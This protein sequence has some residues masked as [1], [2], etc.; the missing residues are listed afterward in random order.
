[1]SEIEKMYE[2]AGCT[3]MW[4]QRYNDGYYEHEHHYNSYKEMI[5]RMMK[6]NDWTLTEAQET[7][8]KECSK[9]LPPFT[10]EKQI[11]LIK[12]LGCRRHIDINIYNIKG[13]TVYDISND[14]DCITDEHK[15]MFDSS[16]FENALAGL[17]NQVYYSL[18]E[19]EKQQV[20]GI[21]ER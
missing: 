14:Y 9:E 11:K 3:N 20:K 21:L 1:M 13:C 15:F 17:I 6:I 8:K 12:W 7:A 4:V 19:E 18:T 2:N 5:N 10:A 16:T